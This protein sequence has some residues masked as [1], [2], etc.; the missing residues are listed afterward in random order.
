MCIETQYKYTVIISRCISCGNF[1][2]G[3]CSI[4]KNLQPLQRSN[5][6]DNYNQFMRHLVHTYHI[7]IAMLTLCIYGQLVTYCAHLALACISIYGF[8]FDGKTVKAFR[9]RKEIKLKWTK[10]SSSSQLLSNQYIDRI[11]QSVSGD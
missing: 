5:M 10:V 7:T 8:N 9:Q 4:Y 6:I 11:L 1:E 2:L 3:N